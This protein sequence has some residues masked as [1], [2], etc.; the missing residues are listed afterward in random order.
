MKSAPSSQPPAYALRSRRST[1]ER[2]GTPIEE[3]DEEQSDG[4]GGPAIFEV[5]MIS[6][7]KRKECKLWFLARSREHGH[8]LNDSEPEE[9]FDECG[10][11]ILA[12]NIDAKHKIS[13]ESCGAVKARKRLPTGD[14][15]QRTKRSKQCDTD[16]VWPTAVEKYI[17]LSELSKVK[18]INGCDKDNAGR[19]EVHV[20]WSNGEQTKHDK[21]II[22][23]RCPQ[24]MLRYYEKN[25]RI[26]IEEEKSKGNSRK[27]YSL[28][29]GSWETKIEKIERL[30]KDPAGRPT[31]YVTWR[32]N[33]KKT[34]HDAETMY[35]KCPQMVL[36]FY[37]I[38]IVGT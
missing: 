21:E 18:T 17:S 15:Q 24:K 34:M 35:K 2:T 32:D 7:H 33:T 26:P 3:L 37:E 14:E 10:K 36:R 19:L 27:R 11:G 22:Y 30:G 5:D 23:E 13:E 6:K 9:H 38:H 12:Q 8:H 4:E 29:F 28:P 1:R 31:F 16:M 20:T 25:A